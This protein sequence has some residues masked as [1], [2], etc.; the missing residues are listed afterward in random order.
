MEFAFNGIQPFPKITNLCYQWCDVFSSG[1]G[2]ANGFGF[3]VAFVTQLFG[4][5]LK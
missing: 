1:L 3:D 2:F 5:R 4:Q